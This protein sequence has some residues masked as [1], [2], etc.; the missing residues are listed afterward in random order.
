MAAPTPPAIIPAPIF[1][2]SFIVSPVWG[3][4]LLLLLL[5]EE[6]EEDGVEAVRASYIP[7]RV[8]E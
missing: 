8:D 3:R 5:E 7:N 2:I 1:F 4:G 6:E